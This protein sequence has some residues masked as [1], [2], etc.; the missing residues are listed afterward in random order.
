VFSVRSETCRIYD[1]NFPYIGYSFVVGG[2]ANVCVRDDGG[3]S[4]ICILDFET[5]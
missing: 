5:I 3:T 4:Q 1:G 2:D